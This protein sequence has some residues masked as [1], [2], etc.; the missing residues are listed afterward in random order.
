ML[1]SMQADVLYAPFQASVASHIRALL[2]SYITHL[3]D[4]CD[5]IQ[6]KAKEQFH[7]DLQQ[8][9]ADTASSGTQQLQ[10]LHDNFQ[11]QVVTDC[12]H[13]I[14]EFQAIA[15]ECMKEDIAG[16][17]RSAE[18]T[19][20]T[21]KAAL[22][23][24][25]S[26]IVK[27]AEQLFSN[28][29]QQLQHQC[30]A[31]E[32]KHAEQMGGLNAK[33][34]S[35][36]TR[37]RDTYL[38]HCEEQLQQMRDKFKVIRAEQIAQMQ[39][40]RTAL[41]KTRSDL[42]KEHEA[43]MQ[44][45]KTTSEAQNAAFQAERAILQHQMEQLKAHAAELATFAKKRQQDSN[46]LKYIIR[47]QESTSGSVPCSLFGAE[48]NSVLNKTFNGEWAYATDDEG[49]AV[50]NS[51]AAHWP[52]ILDWLSFGA[53]PASPTDAFVEE[54]GYWQLDNLLQQIAQRTKPPDSPGLHVPPAASHIRSEHHFFS[55]TS[56]VWSGCHGYQLSGK[57]YNFCERFTAT[58]V[59]DPPTC[60]VCV[61]FKACGRQWELSID[62][63]GT[64]LERTAGPKV[65]SASFS[66]SFG[67]DNVVWLHAPHLSFKDESRG[68]GKV[69]RESHEIDKLKSLPYID[70]HGSLHATLQLFFKKST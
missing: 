64:F 66:I 42:I 63:Q 20:G 2:A 65:N 16:L 43:Q 4:A 1:S 34:S 18:A 32:A 44:E 52:L 17:Q 8:V 6:K 37:L 14:N 29:Q 24:D 59:A 33:H 49:R 27:K 3:V 54:C 60:S 7:A 26:G 21:A 51:S 35:D 22:A 56:N 53:V 62:N 28:L 10:Q 70:I 23:A 40:F 69:W 41:Q 45:L 36:L 9:A 12:Q 48:P 67:Q 13:L 47:G 57:I 15:E 31:Y 11:S 46:Q 30:D 50:I 55:L 61:G 5:D 25:V 38:T 39:T 58:Q 68:Y 19:T